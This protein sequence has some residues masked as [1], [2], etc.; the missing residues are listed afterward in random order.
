MLRVLIADDSLFMVQAIRRLIEL[1]G[2]AVQA[3]A[4][5]GDVA[6]EK[7]L[8]LRPDI[9]ILDVNMPGLDGTE[10]LRRIKATDPDAKVIMVTADRHE[11]IEQRCRDLGADEYIRKQDTH[12][13]VARIRQLT[14]MNE[15]PR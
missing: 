13:V 8:A 15:A 5:S 14:H 12:A 2:F 3:T 9:A 7:W 1:G 10:V 6:L 4:T 11:H